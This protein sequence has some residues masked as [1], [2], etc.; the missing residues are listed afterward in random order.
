MHELLET[1]E[2]SQ[3]H[4]IRCVK[5]NMLKKASF[6]DNDFVLVQLRCVTPPSPYFH[7]FHATRLI[8]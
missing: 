4:F 5:P 2:K 7:F 8:E 6:F 3:P 1:L